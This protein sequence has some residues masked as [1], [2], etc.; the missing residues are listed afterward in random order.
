M[1]ER[2]KIVADSAIPFLKGVFE[3]YCDISY[4]EGA[5][6]SASDVRDA[7][8]LLIRTRT[9]CDAALLEGSAVKLIATATIGY[10]HIDMQYCND[11]G[12]QVAT[13]AG[14]NSRGVVQYVIAALAAISCAEGWAPGDK[15][16]G[17]VGVGN[18][19]NALRRIG[20]ALGFNILCCDP[21]R[22]ERELGL[23][24]I[25]L[26]KL[27]P[28]CD[29]VSLHLPLTRT[30]TH[31]T[32]SLAD[33][34]FF[35]LIKLGAIFINS[36]RGE[37]CNEKELISAIGHHKIS[38]AVI[39]TW[40]AEPAINRDLLRAATFS[41][42]HIAGYS[43]QGKAMGTAMIVGAAA[44]KFSLPLKN[45]YPPEVTPSREDLSLTWKEIIEKMP[46]YFDIA[47]QSAELKKDPERFE[48]MRD[49]YNFRREF[50]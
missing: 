42:P 9:R 5:A 4:I 11:R 13:A 1:P 26:E 36:S 27:L 8:C 31:K 28:R 46:S 22:M 6:I 41:T 47:A 32:I 29:I 12:I 20:E 37:V 18:I 24:F 15:T 39:D 44:E 21:P 25:T 7:D 34:E 3:P 35:N 2:I 49:N 30:G 45:W 17:I 38:H 43:I 10:D 19:G 48:Q 16:L 14:C 50:F 23:G 40:L 33:K